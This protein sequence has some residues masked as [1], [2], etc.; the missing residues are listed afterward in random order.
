[1]G[2]NELDEA[3]IGILKVDIL[4][5]TGLSHVE[6]DFPRFGAHVAKVGISHLSGPI[7]NTSHD[8]DS[9]AVQVSGFLA[10]SARDLLE[11]EKGSP[12][13][14]TGNEFC[15]EVEQSSCLQEVEG[16]LL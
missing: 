15:L 16:K 8:R 13:P 12:A 11:V 2:F 10:D 6:I 14:W 3:L 7:H 1:M 5:D 9:D 4:L